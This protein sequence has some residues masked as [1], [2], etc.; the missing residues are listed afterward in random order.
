MRRGRVLWLTLITT[1][2]A[3]S[4]GDPTC[5][6]GE[7]NYQ[8]CCLPPPT[9]NPN[10]WDDT[11]T[12]QRC[13][14]EVG[15]A[16]DINAVEDISQLGGC[17]LNI[18]QEFKARSGAW[19]RNGTPNLVLFQE[20][21]YIA[22][23]FDSM[24]RSCAPAALT[25]LLMKLESI[26][27]EED[28]V[29]TALYAHYTEQHHEAVANGALL[30]YQPS[31]L[32]VITAPVQYIQKTGKAMLSKS[33][34]PCALPHAFDARGKV[35]GA[36]SHFAGRPVNG[37]E[38]HKILKHGPVALVVA[39]AVTSRRKAWRVHRHAQEDAEKAGVEAVTDDDI[40]LLRQVLP[41]VKELVVLRKSHT[42]V[43]LQLARTMVPITVEEGEVIAQQGQP[44]D[45]MY[46]IA[47]GD[48][49]LEI[50]RAGRVEPEQRPVSQGSYIGAECLLGNTPHKCSASAQTSC[51]LLRLDRATFDSIIL[52]QREEEDDDDEDEDDEGD[53]DTCAASQ[54]VNIFVLS[55]STGESA[56]ASVKT[57]AAQF[58]YCS[59]STCAT[60]RATVYRFVRS[61]A[62]IK[63]IVQAAKK[64]NAL[65]VYTIMD[66][67][68]QRVLVEECT[69]K[70]LECIDLW[71]PL[72][73]SFERRFGAKRSGKAGRRQ[74]VSDDYMT[75]V[76]AIEYTRKVDDGVLPHLWD[77][78]DVMLIGPSRAGKTPLSFYLAQRGYKVANY[79][80]VPEEEPPKE[81]FEIDQQK[82][83]ALQIKPERLREIR[84]QRM[85]QFNRSN[86]QY[87]NLTNIKK[88]VSWIK[89]FYLRKGPK[90]PIIDTSNAGVVETAARIMEILDRRK[91]DAVAASY[92]QSHHV[93]GWPLVDGLRKI[94]ALRA[95]RPPGE[96]R[97]TAVDLVLCYCGRGERIEW[98]HGFHR[99]PWRQ[100]DR[101]AAIRA[102]VAL[103]IYHKCGSAVAHEREEESQKL[104]KTWSSWFD[105]VQVRYVDD[106]VRADDCSAYLAYVVDRY[107]D[108]PEF[109]VFLHADAPEHIPTIDLLMDT[110]FAAARGYLPPEAGFIHLAHN[111]VRHDCPGS[112]GT[113]TTPDAFE[114]AQLWRKV[115]QS[116]ITP[117]MSEGE[118][119]G[120]CCVQFLVRRERIR[121]RS[122]DFYVRA[123]TFFGAPSYHALFPVGKV[124]WEPDTRGRTPCQLNMYFWH[125][126]FG[127]DLWLPR[128]HRDKRLPLFIRILNIEAEAAVE[129]QRGEDGPG[130]ALIQFTGD[131]AGADD[132]YYRLQSLFAES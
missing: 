124:V 35:F 29:W 14:R 101:S 34:K 27:F 75:I 71:G 24:Y 33:L 91:G 17:E 118:L 108:M 129:A 74:T 22:R 62:E 52:S 119:N 4:Q 116:S 72:L 130:A 46:I 11:Y 104:I 50:P 42:D 48:V 44:D 21:G 61:A 47:E 80:L 110:V 115:F 73:S 15:E 65:L 36:G 70:E 86:T 7:I 83:F 66:P 25:A 114:V 102:S 112:T 13:C 90:W 41:E 6:L 43:I 5:W 58:E 37:F 120:Y 54:L 125:V 53:G 128:R 84:T 63:T 45:S 55:D 57:A 78:C 9:G 38:A 97:T 3:A 40:S 93:N 18:F 16:V 2:V 39:G 23:R 68:L 19:Y 31:S 59:G 51:R 95:L 107:D 109:A 85:K 26:Y 67:K 132:T 77:E 10:C 60:S 121:L 89:N 113:C 49:L 127:E 12:Y 122:K 92:Q 76:K 8:T 103:R 32:E 69:A 96:S 82:C 105:T 117:V 20:F 81:L 64:S 87:A 79:P 28:A 126:M 123:L 94:N 30:I 56:N 98:L 131:N 99:L 88:E 106:E 111:Y 100:E 1:A